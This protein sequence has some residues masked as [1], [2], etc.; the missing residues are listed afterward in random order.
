MKGRWFSGDGDEDRIDKVD[1]SRP[2]DE[3][4]KWRS[5]SESKSSI[6]DVEA[7]LAKLDSCSVCHEWS[8]QVIRAVLLQ[9][10]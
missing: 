6:V 7:A 8:F 10:G 5:S 4:L 2:G 3:G 1:W 9:V